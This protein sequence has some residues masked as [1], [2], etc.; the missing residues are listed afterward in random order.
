MR[1]RGA[2]RS[3]AA[4][5]VG[6][7]YRTSIVR[8]LLSDSSLDDP[9]RERQFV[10]E[11]MLALE[12]HRYDR[13]YFYTVREIDPATLSPAERAARTEGGSDRR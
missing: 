2:A 12:S 1:G 11:V 3:P 9:E 8:R 4:G 10:E 7:R 5:C 13:E 6:P